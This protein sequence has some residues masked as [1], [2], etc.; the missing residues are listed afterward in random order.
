MD[1]TAITLGRFLLGLY[2]LV[3]GLTKITSYQAMIAY[4]TLHNIPMV[5]LLLPLTTAL[6]IG[7]GLFLITGFRVKETAY[8]FVGMTLLINLGMHDFWN[9]YPDV[10]QKHE[11]QNF[12]KNL[13][14]LAGLLV[15]SASQQV[16]QW[17]LFKS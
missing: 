3:P 5:E 17:R 4:M 2:F 15:L 9:T 8:M 10:D 1:R 16:E 14:I 11:L 12:V 6:Q 7:G 13:G